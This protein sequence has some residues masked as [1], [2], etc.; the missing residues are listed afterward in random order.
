MSDFVFILPDAPVTAPAAT[1]DETQPIEHVAAALDRVPT[2]L[3]DRPNRNYE[4]LL[5][6]IVTPCQDLEDAAWVLLDRTLATT[7][8]VDLDR[9]GRIVG[10][11]RL[12]SASDDDYRATLQARIAV[13]RSHGRLADIYQIARL[14]AGDTA[15]LTITPELYDTYTLR[16]TGVVLTDAIGALLAADV[17]AATASGYRSLVELLTEDEDDTFTLAIAAF[18]PASLTAGATSIIVTSTAGFPDT[19]TLRI[20]DGITG[21]ETVTYTGRTSTT[22]TGVS[23]LA[24]NHTGTPVPIVLA[25]AGT[26]PGLGDSTT[27]ATG[28]ALTT[29]LE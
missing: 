14:L 10:R 16:V 24:N 4:R 28:G 11:A 13:N 23:A 26:P 15:T 8:G 7:T 9:V 22:F 19:G 29:V 17:A 27:P 2:Y 18:A 21:E 1:V 6:A 20:D 25:S 12:T 3:R 5:E